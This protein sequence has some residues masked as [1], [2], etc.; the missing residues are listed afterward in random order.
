MYCDNNN[1]KRHKKRTTKYSVK[2]LVVMRQS[3]LC[4]K[5]GSKSGQN[6]NKHVPP[7]PVKC[8][9]YRKARCQR[10]RIQGCQPLGCSEC[11]PTAA[12][13]YT[14]EKYYQGIMSL[15]WSTAFQYNT[16]IFNLTIAIMVSQISSFKSLVILLNLYSQAL[17]STYVPL[18][19]W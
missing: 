4:R 13:Y 19:C 3:Q 14:T 17:H 7:L 6:V 18:S 1:N 16:I 2:G 11:K 10:R 8:S 5:S 12:S 15:Y 9:V